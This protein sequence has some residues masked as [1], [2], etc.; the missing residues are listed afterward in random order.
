L[1]ICELPQRYFILYSLQI[2]GYGYQ[3]A[4]AFS[5]RLSAFELVSISERLGVKFAGWDELSEAIDRHRFYPLMLV[6]LR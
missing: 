2:L 1:C 4:A 6:P 5:L 3:H